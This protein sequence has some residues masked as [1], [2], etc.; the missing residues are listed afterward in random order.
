NHR[1]RTCC[2]NPLRERGNRPN[3]SLYASVSRS[4]CAQPSFREAT[5]PGGMGIIDVIQ[6]AEVKDGIPHTDRNGGGFAGV[7]GGDLAAFLRPESAAP[8]GR[9]RLLKTEN[10]VTKI[11][12]PM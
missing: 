2:T 6:D 9:F 10:R 11:S 12:T 7:A 8:A 3:P 5:K 1:A 4:R